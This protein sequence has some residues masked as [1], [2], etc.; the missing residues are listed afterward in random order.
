MGA[1]TPAGQGGRSLSEKDIVTKR[2]HRRTFLSAF[3]IGSA[4][5]LTAVV[6]GGCGG[7]DD[8]TCRTVVDSDP[9]DGTR[10]ICDND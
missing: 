2:L 5:A 6:V 9:F 8:D 1:E 3:G 7:R 10:T 4:L